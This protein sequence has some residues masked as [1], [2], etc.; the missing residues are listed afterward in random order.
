MQRRLSDADW[1]AVPPSTV[2]D[3]ELPIHIPV[4]VGGVELRASVDVDA[5]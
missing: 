4:F 1:P 2:A 3:A 5:A